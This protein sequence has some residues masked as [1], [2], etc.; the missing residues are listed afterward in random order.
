MAKV[1][2]LKMAASIQTPKIFVQC[3]QSIFRC[4]CLPGLA[5]GKK[6][7]N[8]PNSNKY[9]GM[10]SRMFNFKKCQNCTSFN[11][12]QNSGKNALHVFLSKRKPCQ[13]AHPWGF[14]GGPRDSWQG[15]GG[16]GTRGRPLHAVLAHRGPNGNN[17]QGHP[18]PAGREAIAGHGRPQE[19]MLEKSK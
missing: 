13:R 17:R 15:V 5:D 6:K 8:L 19:A 12:E 1:T 11:L 4:F 2:A 3:W 7:P 16:R 14:T 9:L 18:R 10:C